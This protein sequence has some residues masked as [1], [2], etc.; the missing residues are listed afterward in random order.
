MSATEY[1]E[2]AGLDHL[3]EVERLQA[4][5]AEG[6]LL[7]EDGEKAL[8]AAHTAHQLAVA[9][10]VSDVAGLQG[11]LKK[12]ARDLEEA[13]AAAVAA[14]QNLADA[15]GVIGATRPEYERTVKAAR[16]AGITEFNWV[17]KI[18]KQAS[19]DR[20]L[21]QLLAAARASISGDW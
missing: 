2:Q 5:K 15:V 14:L 7:S 1:I 9:E 21:W 11:R 6:V 12:E 8:A 18:G 4:L 19:D 13:Y 17:P 3:A 10:R 16:N 20:A